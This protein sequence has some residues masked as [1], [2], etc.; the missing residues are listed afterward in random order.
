MGLRPSERRRENTAPTFDV[1]AQGARKFATI[2]PPLAETSPLAVEH[3]V[4]GFFNNMTPL[5]TA[6]SDA[7]L[8]RT[9]MGKSLDVPVPLP[10]TQAPLSPTSAFVVRDPPSRTATE[11]WF[12]ARRR[13]FDEG[14]ASERVVMRM[15]NT[16]ETP[17]GIA[18]AT[19]ARARGGAGLWGLDEDRRMD[20]KV[21]FKEAENVLEQYWQSE[22]EIRQQ[23][24]DGTLAPRAARTLLDA[25][26]TERQHMLRETR[27]AL[28]LL[29]VPSD[30][31]PQ[32]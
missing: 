2:M 31:R 12:Y 7:A 24:N 23:V 26:T 13:E 8:R 17:A 6:V 11:A 16:A 1:L 15:E 10:L 19:G 3:V 9:A 21:T 20:V 32:P 30:T 14:Q 18:R 5:L 27:A 4:R 28:E 25:L 29:G 22:T